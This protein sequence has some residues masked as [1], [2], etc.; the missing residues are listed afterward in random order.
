MLFVDSWWVAVS[1][2]WDVPGTEDLQHL[3]KDWRTKA[4]AKGAKLLVVGLPVSAVFA[5]VFWALA[6]FV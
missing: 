3:Y 6:R 5:A 1:G 2:W 4:R